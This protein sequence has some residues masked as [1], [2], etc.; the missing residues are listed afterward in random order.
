MP[1]DYEAHVKLLNTII[2]QQAA[3]INE[4]DLTI[5]ELRT[6]VDEL[7]SLKVNLEETLQTF[8][9]QLFGTKS[10]KSASKKEDN[11][12]S[13]PTTVKEHARTRKSKTTRDEIGRAHV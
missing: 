3:R 1:V 4:Q 7:R 6:L 5:K 13:T 11:S 2:E 8:S 9:R 12:S 10:E